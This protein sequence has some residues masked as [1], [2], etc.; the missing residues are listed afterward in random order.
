MEQT[1]RVVHQ[2]EDFG[3][4]VV[5]VVVISRWRA[6][7]PAARM[8]QLLEVYRELL[9]AGPHIAGLIWMP[10]QRFAPPDAE[11]RGVLV[12]IE[13][14][15]GSRSL[16]LGI[17]LEGSPMVLAT[18]RAVVTGVGLVS[19]APYPRAIVGTFAEGA[20]FVAERAQGPTSTELITASRLLDP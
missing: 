1:G 15:I 17:V 16:A 5:G 19:R 8:R 18:A 4:V 12:D 9:R 2:S 3:V 10:K 7:L 20:A 14:E 6:G 13:K 11:A